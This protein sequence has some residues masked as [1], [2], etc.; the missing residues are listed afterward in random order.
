MSCTFYSSYAIDYK[1]LC[2]SFVCVVNGFVGDTGT[3]GDRRLVV[4][5]M[6][7][8]CGIFN[9]VAPAVAKAGIKDIT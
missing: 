7:L 1:A 8:V 3:L 2:R 4:C 9:E 6:C 5:D